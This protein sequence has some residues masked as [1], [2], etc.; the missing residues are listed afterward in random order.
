MHEFNNGGSQIPGK[1]VPNLGTSAFLGTDYNSDSGHGGWRK[2]AI[3]QNS[4]LLSSDPSDYAYPYNNGV[5]HSQWRGGPHQQPGYGSLRKNS[6]T[7]HPELG[8]RSDSSTYAESERGTAATSP[9]TK[10]D[11]ETNTD[12]SHLLETSMKR[13]QSARG[14]NSSSLGTGG[15]GYRRPLSNVSTSS[16]G[17]NKSSS[18]K[19]SSTVGSRLAKHGVD[20]VHSPIKVPGDGTAQSSIPRPS[21]GGSKIGMGHKDIQSDMGPESYNS[22]TLERRRKNGGLTPSK[23]TGV[24]PASQDFQSNTLGRRRLFD[25]K[26]SLTRAASQGEGGNLCPSTIISNPHATY[27][28]GDK[29]TS[30]YVNLQ[31]LQAAQQA[32]AALQ[33]GGNFVQTG[34]GNY[35]VVEYCSPRN[36]GI[37]NGSWLKSGNGHGHPNQVG[38]VGPETEESLSSV[39][40]SIQAQIQQARALSGASARILAQTREALIAAGSVQGLS[41]SCSIKSTQSDCLHSSSSKLSDSEDLPRTNSFSQLTSPTSTQHPLPPSSPT[42]SNSSHT[43]RFTYPMTYNTNGVFSTSIPPPPPPNMVR[44]NTQSSLPFSGLALSKLTKSDE[45]GASRK[46]FFCFSLSLVSC[47]GCSLLSSAASVWNE[48]ILY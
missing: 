6:N 46:C 31:Q 33:A 5:D 32:A 9:A 28:K 22:S 19:G 7:S 37:A 40:S 35:A 14:A 13:M 47:P 41:R 21:S 27:G 1:R 10:R 34:G 12:N 15:F 20:P 11:C 30:H 42:P 8:Y 18:S 26:G 17:S 24:G 39:A 25:S 29:Q 16:I 23:S 36:S 38:G 45:D 3:P 48:K 44:S 43:S 2:Y 4:K